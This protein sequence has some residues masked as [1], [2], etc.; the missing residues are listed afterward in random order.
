MAVM[1]EEKVDVVVKIKREQG[2][3]L[4]CMFKI[5]VTVV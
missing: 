4:L 3:K 2:K 5:K 1:D